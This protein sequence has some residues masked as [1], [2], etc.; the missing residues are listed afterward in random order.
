MYNADEVLEK[1]HNTILKVANKFSFAN[2]KF[3]FE[4]LVEEG[5][6]AAINAANSYDPS[7][8]IKFITYLM[9]SLN[10][11]LSKFVGDNSFDLEVSEYYR[12]QEYAQHGSLEHLTE[13]C[14]ALRLDISGPSNESDGEPGQGNNNLHGVIP[15]GGPN[16]Q[17]AMIRAESVQILREEMDSLPDREKTVL[18]LRFLDGLTLREIAEQ[19]DV[20]KQTIHGWQ[21]KGFDRLSK[22]V[23]ARMGYELY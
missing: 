5:R 7:K 2:S 21:K 13:P 4:D 12:R 18:Q 3:D 14:R 16:P 23:K 22:R 10:R 17:D 9:N 19:M 6:V 1:Y 8:D 15:S 20:T 11:E